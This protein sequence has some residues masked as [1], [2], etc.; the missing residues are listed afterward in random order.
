[1]SKIY[2]RK[3]DTGT[4]SLIGGTRVSKDHPQVAAYGEVDTLIGWIGVIRCHVVPFDPFLRSIQEELMKICALLA[5]DSQATSSC[6]VSESAVA[7][8]EAQIDRMQETLPPLR[9]FILPAAPLAAAYANVART[10][11]RHAERLT[12]SLPVYTQYP[13]MGAYLNRLSDYLFTLA[14]YLCVSAGCK[15]DYWQ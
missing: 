1:M 10:V 12:V 5:T 6:R 9:H 2:T 14:R 11:C 15:E 13:A 4:T 7:S 8:L 3:G